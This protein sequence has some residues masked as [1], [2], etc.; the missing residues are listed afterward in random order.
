[1]ATA[2][3]PP[4][5]IYYVDPSI[6]MDGVSLQ[7]ESIQEKEVNLTAIYISLIELIDKYSADKDAGVPLRPD[8][9]KWNYFDL[10]GIPENSYLYH[11]NSKEG[12]VQP[13]EPYVSITKGMRLVLMAIS[14]DIFTK[15]CKYDSASQYGTFTFLPN[16]STHQ[17]FWRISKLSPRFASSYSKLTGKIE[18]QYKIH[19]TPK[20]EY[21][22]YVIFRYL[23]MIKDDDILNNNTIE[24]KIILDF[25]SDRP[26]LN[27]TD[28]I[29]LNGGASPIMVLYMNTD[30]KLVG[31]VLDK[32][33]NEF[34]SEK[35]KLGAM[36]PDYKYRVLPFNV[37][38]N[39]LLSYAQGDRCQKLDNREGFLTG[40][41]GNPKSFFMAKWVKD[42]M[43]NEC[44]NSN[45]AAISMQL[46]GKNIC[47]KE[48]KRE[49]QDEFNTDD[50]L[51][52]TAYPEDFLDPRTLSNFKP[53]VL[54]RA[55]EEAD[56]SSNNSQTMAT[57]PLDFP[58]SSE[59]NTNT[60]TNIN[61]NNNNNNNNY[62]FGSP[63]PF[64]SLANYL[65]SFFS[66]KKQEGGKQ[67]KRKTKKSKR[68]S[69]QPTKVSKRKLL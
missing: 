16:G 30:S 31:K 3:F 24:S 2:R 60:N 40:S 11:A 34:K 21:L 18:Q 55:I 45:T 59:T 23:S 6:P 15:I 28:Q 64:P 17:M 37:R 61:R 48:N 43:N 10:L 38:L 49:L 57:C 52:M 33:L 50:L 44:N 65:P 27:N 1:M 66:K 19:I 26:L 22:F 39:S 25:R 68:K 41:I 42:M 14:P 32:L 8:T 20:H 29:R 67:K 69:K 51:W 54:G 36:T 53:E 35:D 46:F 62:N 58:I 5:K 63:A 4:C 7:W 47:D 56:T 12:R 13:E 9:Y